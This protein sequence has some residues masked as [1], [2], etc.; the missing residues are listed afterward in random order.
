MFIISYACICDRDREIR[1][2]DLFPSGT[3][4]CS[5]LVVIWVD[6]EERVGGRETAHLTLIASAYYGLAV[7][8]GVSTKRTR[9]ASRTILSLIRHERMR[10]SCFVY[11]ARVVQSREYIVTCPSACVHIW[12]TLVCEF[13]FQP[14]SCKNSCPCPRLRYGEWSIWSRGVY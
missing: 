7:S 1:R 6:S 9:C 5:V 12:H 3:W 8:Q 10:V 11:D 14:T 13:P 4:D 2:R